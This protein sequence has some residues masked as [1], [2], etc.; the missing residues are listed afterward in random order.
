MGT[1]EYTLF[2]KTCARKNPH[3][4]GVGTRTFLSNG[5][6]NGCSHRLIDIHRCDELETIK[7]IIRK[8]ISNFM[9]ITKFIDFLDL[10]KTTLQLRLKAQ[11]GP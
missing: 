1:H 9:K 2:T 10:C 5:A 7:G 8:K 11:I 6:S 3:M 4:C